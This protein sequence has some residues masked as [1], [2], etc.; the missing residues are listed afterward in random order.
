MNNIWALRGSVSVTK[1][2]APQH[3]VGN[4]VSGC[5]L[6]FAS[7]I[8]RMGE[9]KRTRTGASRSQDGEA[10]TAKSQHQ[11]R[12]SSPNVGVHGHTLLD[13]FHTARPHYQRAL[14]AGVVILP[15]GQY[16]WWSC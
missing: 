8:H 16:R 13:V 6:Q 10:R 12:G 4:T 14:F 11:N 9:N 7:K 2:K 15:V 1:Y 5:L 3:I